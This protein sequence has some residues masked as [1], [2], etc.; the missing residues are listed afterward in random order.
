M[1]MG[2]SANLP[3]RVIAI[4]A[5]LAV[6][7]APLCAPLCRSHACANSEAKHGDDCH[8]SSPTEYNSPQTV[9]FSNHI[10]GSS[11]LPSAVLNEGTN[12]AERVKQGLAAHAYTNF[13]LAKPS[14]ID[15]IRGA[16]DPLPDF[17]AWGESSSAPPAV[18]RI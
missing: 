17:R 5:L 18:L 7:I 13:V 15:A 10:C 12:S 11:E 8:S 4:F 1:K 14:Q 6:L 16:Y 3:R 2:P 9:V